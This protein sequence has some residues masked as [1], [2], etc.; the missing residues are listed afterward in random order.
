LLRAVGLSGLIG[1]GGCTAQ[2][3]HRSG[4]EM[5][6]EGK[7]EAGLDA[8]SRAAQA[9][10]GDVVL[11]KDYYMAKTGA[12]NALLASAQRR[13]ASG[14]F[15]GAEADLRKLQAIDPANTAAVQGLQSL[16][17]AAAHG[18]ML[19][20]ARR[21][22]DKGDGAQAA[23]LVRAIL[24][25]DP[26]QRDALELQRA[27]EQPRFREHY[28]EA[29][30]KDSYAKPI[31]LEF[32][33]A[34]VRQVLEALS[35]VTGINFIFDKDVPA[36]L[37]TTIFLRDTDIDEA[38]DLI[39]HNCQLRSKVLNRSSVQI[40]PD[41]LEK[42]KDYQELVVRAFYLQDASAA[43]IQTV[44][45]TLLKLKD[46]VIDERLNL[47]TVR[48]TPEAI[49]L[50]ERLVALHDLAEPEVMLEVE[51][52][53]VQRDDLL[54]LGVQLPNQ[55]TALMPAGSS[56]GS[57]TLDELKRVNASNLGLAFT[58]PSL[59]LRQDASLSNLLAN[60]RIRVHNHE[61]ANVM[62]GDKVPVITTTSNATGFVAEN[63]QYLDVGLKLNAEP[64]IH[65]SSDVS[66]RLNLEVSSIANQVSTPNG[67]VAYQVGTR[68]ASTF[69]RLHD[70]E[71]QVLAGLISDQD[72][73]S[74]SGVPGLSR[75][76]VLGRLFAA[77]SDTASK[78]EIVLSI[79]P[80]VVRPAVRAAA[81]PVE[82]WSGTENGLDTKPLRLADRR[83]DARDA[84]AVPAGT[85]PTG[86]PTPAPAPPQF[87]WSG[88]NQ[89][90][91]GEEFVLSLRVIAGAGTPAAAFR[92]DVDDAVLEVVDV[93][94]APDA[95][96][97][98]IAFDRGQKSLRLN[99]GGP[100]DGQLLAMKLRARV[101]APST[102][103]RIAGPAADA[104]A[105]PPY[106]IAVTP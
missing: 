3:L 33:D 105:A 61:K 27:L 47:V 51:V 72:R 95:G 22:L 68:N 24:A 64:V 17:R 16:R 93:D 41:T 8:L 97:N 99:L 39:L 50:A 7:V 54:K 58:N 20:A 14:D 59:N 13:Q 10:P 48:D 73:H 55:F 67:T 57:L 104:P 38:L 45:K 96:A 83:A 70:G 21:A 86:M 92:V 76:P 5:M 37:R 46:V 53:E 87:V 34:N 30:L 35:R 26:G 91:A 63:V 2:M 25:D 102:V 84:T 42:R 32:R 106:A 80:H 65:P 75:L 4:M 56:G 60:P 71:T 77:P 88:P 82:F 23:A 98:G 11:R 1:L 81:Q 31:N 52:L 6:G 103:V 49:Q 89:V 94:A 44:L 74:A 29:R 12:V 85:G 101:P 66:I 78:T 19:A 90:K 9:A 36:D 69:L 40:Y 15:A 79:T 100:M 62:I 28:V 18:D 43:Q